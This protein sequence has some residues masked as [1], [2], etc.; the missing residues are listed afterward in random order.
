MLPQEKDLGELVNGGVR[1]RC[2]L[3]LPAGG[4]YRGDGGRTAACVRDSAQCVPVY[5]VRVH[6]TAI[7]CV[8]LYA[9]MWVNVWVSVWVS[10][11]VCTIYYI[12]L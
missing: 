6:F 12:Y 2:R 9:W 1:G 7:S 11:W 8:S 10:V 5:Q 4:E 3:I